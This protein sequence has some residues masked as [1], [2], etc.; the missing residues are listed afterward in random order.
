MRI[1]A[2]DFP[3]KKSLNKYEIVQKIGEGYEGEVYIIKEIDTDI[4]RVAKFFFPHRNVK[5]KASKHYAKQLHKLNK[6]NAVVQYHFRGEVRVKGQPVTYLVSELIDGDVLEEY[7]KSKPGKRLQAFEALHVC[8]AVAKAV[9]CIHKSGE[10]HGDIHTE[11]IMVN[12][13]GIGFDIQLIDLFKSTGQYTKASLRKDDVV[14]VIRVLY[15]ILGGVKH[16]AKQPQ[17]IKDI[18][19]GLKRNLILKKFPNINKLIDHL[20]GIS[21]D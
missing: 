12:P 19:C 6:C 2:F 15:D 21:W 17:Q 1:E 7:Q 14:E 13:R 3:A 16:Y 8:Y 18:C 5:D 9:Q 11:N 20:E 4:E 10:Y